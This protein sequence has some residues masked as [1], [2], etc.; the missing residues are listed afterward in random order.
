[1]NKDVWHEGIQHAHAKRQQSLDQSAEYFSGQNADMLGEI[2]FSLV[3]SAA[4]VARAAFTG[5]R[6]VLARTP[7]EIDPTQMPQV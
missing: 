4:F 1:M 7:A 3:R 5:V 2:G 6:A